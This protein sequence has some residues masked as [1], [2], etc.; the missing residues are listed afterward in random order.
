M[1]N[2]KKLLAL[3]PARGGSKGIPV[4]NIMEIAG[5]PLIAYSILQAKASKYINRTI[6][7]TDNKEIAEISKKWGAEVP[8]IRPPEFAQ[9]MS[10]D[11]D[12]FRHVLLWLRKNENYQP[13]LIIQLRPTGPVRKVDLIDLAIEKMLQH[14]EADALRSISLA[15]QTPYKM[16]NIKD[17][18][19]MG[20]LL[21][22]EG[23]ED[24]QS[25]PRQALPTVYWQNGYVDIIRS[26]AILEYHSMWGQKVLPFII[27][28][29]IL[30]MDY[31]ENILAIE[32]ALKNETKNN[33]NESIDKTIRH[34]V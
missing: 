25:L 3:I 27:K 33:E 9:D 13:D 28:E 14:P 17:D 11:I 12:V 15:L 5:K 29:Q 31:P 20:P 24:C 34:S 2:N 18:G 1:I 10:P 23:V 21:K 32:E 26:R 4:K 22:I 30:E 19:L 8:F 7:S 6:V 16:W